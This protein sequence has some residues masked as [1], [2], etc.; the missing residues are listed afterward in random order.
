MLEDYGAGAVLKRKPPEQAPDYAGRRD[1]YVGVSRGF[2]EMWRAAHTPVPFSSTRFSKHGETFCYLKMDG[3]VGLDA[4]RW[5]DRGAIEDEL[6]AMLRSTGLGS[7]VGGATG[8]RYS[9]VDF[10]LLRLDDTIPQIVRLLREG[11][12]MER[13][14]ILFFD[15]CWRD[16]WIGVCERTPPPPM[17]G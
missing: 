4:T 8:I 1:V 17:D 15:S 2:A 7:V 12:M 16:E 6:D 9:Y 5:K 14:W 3:S 10:A 11:R 13:S